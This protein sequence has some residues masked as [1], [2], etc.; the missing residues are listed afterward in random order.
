[1]ILGDGGVA[2]GLVVETR[3]VHFRGQLVA[4]GILPV[5][6]CRGRRTRRILVME[7]ARQAPGLHPAARILLFGDLVAD[8]PEDDARVIAV[9]ARQVAQVLL[10][11]GIEVLAVPV[12][13]L[14]NAPHVEGLVD[15]EQPQPIREFEQLR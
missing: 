10:G 14:G 15:D 2:G 12:G 5:V 13:H 3:D 4:D 11:P 9:A 8:A 1:M 7:E 6:E